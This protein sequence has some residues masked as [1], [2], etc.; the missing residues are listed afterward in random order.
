MLLTALAFALLLCVGYLLGFL[1]TAVLIAY[2]VMSVI[3]FILY[4]VD[5][6]AARHG[7][8]RIPENRLH[9]CSLLGG[10]P[11][12]LLALSMFRHKTRKQSFQVQFW[13]VT[14]LNAGALV[15]WMVLREDF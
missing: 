14:L 12:A 9:L 10:W 1:S 8:Q 7:R 15:G 3:A 4:G 5:K 11:G 13:L 6:Y 2:G